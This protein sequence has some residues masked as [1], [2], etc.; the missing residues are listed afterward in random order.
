MKFLAFEIE[1]PDAAAADFWPHL[2][3]EA[4]KVLQFQQS[5]IIREIYFTAEFHTAVIIIEAEDKNAAEN[6]LSQLPLVKNNLISFEV[7]T[8][9]PYDGFD[10][11]SDG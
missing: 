1:N 11:L 3:D 2:K 4:M 9:L 6:Y 10:R 5:G 7:H 8:L